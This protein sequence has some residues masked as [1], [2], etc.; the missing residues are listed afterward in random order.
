MDARTNPAAMQGLA[1]I[2]SAQMDSQPQ[3]RDNAGMGSLAESVEKFVSNPI[4]WGVLALIAISIGLS[5]RLSVTG[6]TAFV[7]AAFGLA[8]FGIYRSTA[9]HGIDSML[10]FLILGAFGFVLAICAV[11]TN[12]W[13]GH[14]DTHPSDGSGL[15]KPT[16]PS[17]APSLPAPL[18]PSDAGPT[19][20]V[21]QS[22]AISGN[23]NTV[24]YGSSG[25]HSHGDS[26]DPP[27][28][29][30]PVNPEKPKITAFFVQGTSPGAVLTNQ[31]DPVI[32]DPSCSVQMW[33][34]SRSPPV[35]IPTVNQNNPNQFIKKSGGLL[36]ATIDTPTTKPFVTDGDNIFGFVTVDCPECAAPRQYWL[37]FT[38]GKPEGSWYSEIPAGTSINPLTVSRWL[39]DTGWDV[40]Q[41]M[42][43][44][45]HGPLQPVRHLDSL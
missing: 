27:V 7:W 2:S 40:H 11:L 15:N 25:H 16:G 45:A 20:R 24:I 35:S 36:L 34:L 29:K 10:R 4:L 17:S 9:G 18:L 42:A 12:R 6:A 1:E 28:T 33:N 5:G 39:N 13:Y 22:P 37:F 21:P 43:K 26:S 3:Q 31:N 19:T 8:L 14:K 38:Y 41:V 30:P 32:K 23:N 44:V